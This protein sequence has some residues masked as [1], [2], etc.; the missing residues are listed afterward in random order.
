M[1]R[2]LFI[3]KAPSHFRMDEGVKALII[4][5]TFLWSAWHFVTHIFAIFA[6]NEISGGSV[7]IAASAYSVHLIARVFSELA[8]GR[9][10]SGVTRQRRLKEFVIVVAGLLLL[11]VAYIGFATAQTVVVL[12]AGYIASGIGF[13]ISAPARQTFFSLHLD[14]NKEEAE[15]GLRDA[16][17]FGG[18]ALSAALGGF[19]A[20]QYGFRVLFILSA[21]INFLSLIPYFLY[22]KRERRTVLSRIEETVIH[23]T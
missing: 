14:K 4:S 18:M 20:Q 23:A 7:G 16:A 6:V 12:F 17:V 13:G 5:D 19:V 10:L 9:Y 11:S 2:E 1:L 21:I 22:F 8:S 15:W 3:G